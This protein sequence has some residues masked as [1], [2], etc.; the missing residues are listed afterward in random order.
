[1]ALLSPLV[2]TEATGDK[3]EALDRGKTTSVKKKTQTKDKNINK[4]T[5]STNAATTPVIAFNIHAAD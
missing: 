3:D 4:G 2:R 1:L 5:K